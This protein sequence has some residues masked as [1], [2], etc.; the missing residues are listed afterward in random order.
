ML[1]VTW[2][3]D[4][5]ATDMNGSNLTQVSSLNSAKQDNASGD[6]PG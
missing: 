2:N 1:I 4:L 5:L 3:L 6:R